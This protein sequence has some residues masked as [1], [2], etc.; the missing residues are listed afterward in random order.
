MTS[1]FLSVKISNLYFFRSL[2]DGLLDVVDVSV[3]MNQTL[4]SKLP[5][6]LAIIMDGNGRWAKSRGLP[7]IAGHKKG[8]DSVR[9]IVTACRRKGIKNLSLF[10]FSSQNWSRPTLEVNALMSLLANRLVSERSTILENGIRLTA[11][12]E[13][14][15]LPVNTRKILDDLIFES[16]CNTGMTLCLCLSYGGKEEIASMVKS[17]VI[18]AYEGKLNPDS[19]NVDFLENE[20]WSR[21][22]GPVDLLIRTS[23]EQRI[24]NFLLWSIAYAELYFTDLFWPD[25][26]EAA[27]DKSLLAYSERDRRY[28]KVK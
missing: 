14:H 27:L 26:D 20:L 23:G 2:A 16:A 12:G 24:S 13:L 19:I 1:S 9:N 15:L 25:F 22:L 3:D 17:L 18:R 8:A 11:I 4:N 10:A 21:D 28:G 7:R 5:N 6:H